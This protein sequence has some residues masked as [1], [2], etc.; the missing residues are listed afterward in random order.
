MNICKPLQDMLG[1]DPDITIISYVVNCLNNKIEPILLKLSGPLTHF[2]EAMSRREMKILFA[3]HADIYTDVPTLADPDP[4]DFI[5]TMKQID[6][7][8][9]HGDPKQVNPWNK[10]DKFNIREGVNGD[11]ELS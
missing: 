2:R 8:F 4:Y 6:N 10:R 1:I 9:R 5:I 11:D 3:I 7:C